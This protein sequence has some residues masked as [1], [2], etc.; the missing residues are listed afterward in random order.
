MRMLAFTVLVCIDFYL[1]PG[2]GGFYVRGD[3]TRPLY[4]RE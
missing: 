1:E 4:G 2:G 3:S